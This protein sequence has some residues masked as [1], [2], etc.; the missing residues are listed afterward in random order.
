MTKEEEFDR[1]VGLI[2]EAALDTANWEAVLLQISDFV[3]AAGT[4]LWIHDTETNGVYSESIE[5]SFRVVRMD[6]MFS[7]SYVEHYAQTNVWSRKEDLLLSEGA[8]I[9]SSNLFDDSRLPSTEFYG[10]WLRPQDIF[11]SMGV[12]VAKTDT[13]GG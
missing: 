2:Y 10:D 7:A 1:L 8:G 5:E 12:L 9:L 6:P 13:L 11:F 3:C 4:S